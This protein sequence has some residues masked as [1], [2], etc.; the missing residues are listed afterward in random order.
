LNHKIILEEVKIASKYLKLSVKKTRKYSR[1][2]YWPFLTGIAEARA[3]LM[4]DATQ[5][6]LEF[7][8]LRRLKM[9][10]LISDK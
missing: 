3:V 4:S 1:L 10:S 8:S 6:V 2:C 5:K 9:T 7:L